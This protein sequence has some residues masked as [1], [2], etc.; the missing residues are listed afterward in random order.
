MPTSTPGVPQTSG[1]AERSVRTL[2]E[3]IV[4]NLAASGL[5]K[6]WWEYVGPHHACA[7]NIQLV[8]G[9]SSYM[10]RRGVRREA[11]QTP[12][13]RRWTSRRGKQARAKDRLL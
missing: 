5:V 7:R 13:A 3:G 6:R 8:A 12:A 1:L 2:K 11:E 4:T 10:Q 9:D